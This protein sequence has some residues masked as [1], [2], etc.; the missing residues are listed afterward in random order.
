[1]AYTS[2][3]EVKSCLDVPNTAILLLSYLETSYVV[4]RVKTSN[5]PSKRVKVL[6]GNVRC[7]MYNS[8]NKAR[9]S[10]I[11]QLLLAVRTKFHV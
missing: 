4:F 9:I 11:T 3:G 8:I 2:R 5:E 10:S 6:R 1:M 7:T